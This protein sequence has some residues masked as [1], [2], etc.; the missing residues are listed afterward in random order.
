MFGR[1]IQ[2]LAQQAIPMNKAI[3]AAVWALLGLLCTST[4]LS[5]AD[6][7]ETE[8]T[9]HVLA[10][11]QA[12]PIQHSGNNAWAALITWAVPKLNP[13]QRQVLAADYADQI[14]HW[15]DAYSAD[16]LADKTNPGQPVPRLPGQRDLPS[17]RDSLLCGFATRAADC[18]ASV[19][20]QPQAIIEAL[21]P[22][23]DVLEQVAELAHYDHYYSP[24]PAHG[25]LQWPDLRFMR[26]PLSAHALAHVQGD[27]QTALT[28]LCRDAQSGRMLLQH[29][30][31]LLVA[32]IGR[33]I[34]ADS[35]EVAAHIIAELPLDASLPAIC[36]NAFALLSA[37]EMSLCP[38]MRGEFAFMR[39]YIEMEKQRL[40]RNQTPRGKEKPSDWDNLLLIHAQYNSAVC[41]PQTQQSLFK[42][43]K[44]A[45]PKASVSPWL[46]QYRKDNPACMMAQ[47]NQPDYS[48]YVHRMQDMA[49]Q[50][51]MMQVLLWLR[52]QPPDLLLTSDD[53]QAAVP[54]DLYTSTQRAMTISDDGGSL[55]MPA[56]VART[57]EPLR[58]PLPQ[59]L[60]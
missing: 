47:M 34:V 59:A 60:R 43:E 55:E 36:D 9:Q 54:P 7:L 30:S 49:A 4:A 10:L 28:G 51:Q 57:T 19:R 24:L 42:D 35:V 2:A 50:L 3:K 38:A 8:K 5:Q 40:E 15:N 31:D 46:E 52:S 21:A 1:A 16:Y 45:L 23:T 29:S 44:F 12:P 20:Q 17:S 41:L 39:S 18:L 11:M 58:L 13:A 56:Y 25:N 14:K 32:M 26:L 37:E 33:R 6:T 22:Y 48:N 53:L 27:S